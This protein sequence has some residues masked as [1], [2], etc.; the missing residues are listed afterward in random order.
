MEALLDLF[1]FFAVVLQAL[2]LLARTALLGSVMA[3]CL[4][5]FPLAGAHPT[6]A[7]ALA[8]RCRRLVLVAGLA[9]LALTVLAAGLS[10]LALAATLEAGLGAALGAGFVRAALGVIAATALLLALARPGADLSPPRRFGLLA[11]AVVVLLAAVQGSHAMAQTSGRGGMMLAT[12]L[13]QAGAAFWIGGLPAL[14]FALR[15]LEPAAARAAGQRYSTL[16]MV[17]V[18]LIMAGSVGFWLGYIGDV[19][20]VYGTAYGAMAGTKM[21]FLGLL[22]ALGGVNWLLLHRLDAV[23]DGLLKVRRFVECEMAIGVAVLAVAGSL[24]SVPPAKDLIE[25]RV[26]LAEVVER[27]TPGVPRLTSPS[28]QDL[29]IPALQSQLDAEWRQ[30]QARQAERPQA[31]TPGEGLLPPRNAQDIAW[32]EYNHN[33]SGIVVLLVGLAALL[34]ASRRVPFTRHWPLLFLG[35]FLFLFIRSDPEVWPM[36]EIPFFAALRDPE[37]VQHKLAAFLVLGFALA[38]WAVRLGRLGGAWRFV[39]PASMLAGGFLLLSHTHAIG[40][41]KE[42]LLVELS[43]LPLAVC[44]VIAGCA[45][46]VELRGPESM[47]MRARWIWPACLVIIGSFLFIYREA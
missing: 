46:L 13:H 5:A 34:D 20:A 17:G 41:F 31:F 2:L 7:A 42:L 40:N 35:L 29:A 36:G 15:S 11:G 14:W 21:V 30:A 3:W 28:H 44:A 10:V 12:F 9:T 26:S 25:D 18:G 4:L 33:W 47:A 45:R 22:L 24:T 37:V 23:P 38:E 16:A 6:A 8:E 43:H 39:F 27:F 32:S 19:P 1:G